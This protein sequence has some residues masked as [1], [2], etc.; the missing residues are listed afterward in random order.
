M[1]ITITPDITNSPVNKGLSVI[2]SRE[3]ALER[4]NPKFFYAHEHAMMMHNPTLEDQRVPEWTTYKYRRLVERGEDYSEYTRLA[5][6]HDVRQP[7]IKEDILDALKLGNNC[8][9]YRALSKRINNWCSPY[10]IETWLRSHPTY[11]IYAKNIKPGACR[12][13][14]FFGFIVMKN[15]FMHLYRAVMQRHAKSWG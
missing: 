4:Y 13:E 7:Y 2:E 5:K 11:N 6:Q 10:T 8:H 1:G 3:L 15:G 14:I 9:S 12:P